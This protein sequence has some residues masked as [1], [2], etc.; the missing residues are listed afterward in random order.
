MPMMRN[1]FSWI[2]WR[3]SPIALLATASG[4]MMEKVRCNV[5]IRIDCSCFYLDHLNLGRDAELRELVHRFIGQSPRARNNSDVA[6][7]MNVAGHDADLTFSRRDDPRTIG[8]DQP[9]LA[10]YFQVFVGAHHVQHRDALGDADDQRDL[11]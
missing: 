5:C 9:R 6:F 7:F 10:F 3:I 11:G 8:P 1:P 4:L 2:M